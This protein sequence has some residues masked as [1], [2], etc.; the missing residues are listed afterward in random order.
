[1]TNA[2]DGG[3]IGEWASMKLPPAPELRP[4]VVDPRTTA[5]LVLDMM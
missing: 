2:R 5:L 4:V 1:M 3:I